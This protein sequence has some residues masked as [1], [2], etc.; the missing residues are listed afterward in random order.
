MNDPTFRKSDAG[1]RKWSLLPIKP[2]SMIVEVLECGAE[3]YGEHNWRKGADWGR[4]YDALQRHI[5]AWWDGEDD[6]PEWGL[7]HLAHAGC[8]VLFLLYF[9][10]TKTGTDD[11][12]KDGH[13]ANR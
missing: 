2:V 6:D 8:C 13:H 9:V 3:K 1:K 5:T 4:Y 10:A 11:R 7:H 12:Y